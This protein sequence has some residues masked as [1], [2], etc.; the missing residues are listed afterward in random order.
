M[1]ER[2]NSWFDTSSRSRAKADSKY[3][4]LV[5]QKLKLVADLR[6][7]LSVGEFGRDIPFQ[8]KRYFIVFDVPTAETRG[9]HA[10]RTC[11]QFLVCVKGSCGVIVDDGAAR[12]EFVLD[13]PALGLLIPPMIWA[14]QY[15]Y[16]PD[17][18]L[19]VFASELYDADDYI[20][21]YDEFLQCVNK[22]PEK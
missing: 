2:E 18:V 1:S 10:H 17:A 5:P 3:L 13:S 12:S 11:A 9:E 7:H 20:R 14:A 16:T 15:K 8:P 19:L 4:G 21:N 6:G 22:A